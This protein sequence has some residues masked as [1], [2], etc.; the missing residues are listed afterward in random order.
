MLSNINFK[1]F[2]HLEVPKLSKLEMFK[3]Y[4]NCDPHKIQGHKISKK[5][6]KAK[7]DQFR[8]IEEIDKLLN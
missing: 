8:S 4:R 5:I 7:F 6:S 3:K 2:E 1:N